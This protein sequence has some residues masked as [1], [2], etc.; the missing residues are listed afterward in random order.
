MATPKNEVSCRRKV[1]AFS[2]AT[3][4]VLGAIWAIGLHAHSV[5]LINEDAQNYLT[6]V[7]RVIDQKLADA[8]RVRS[9]NVS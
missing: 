1:F 4:V 3:L 7:P 8:I 6:R 5:A 2:I 9:Q